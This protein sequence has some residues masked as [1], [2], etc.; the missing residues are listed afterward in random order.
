ML[1]VFRKDASNFKKVTLLGC[2]ICAVFLMWC[3]NSSVNT[4]TV[5]NIS[6]SI[7]KEYQTIPSSALDNAQIV[8][9]IIGARKSSDGNIIL[10]SSTLP[11]QVSL[12]EFAEKAKTRISQEMI[13]YTNSAI[14]A[15][16]F[17]CYGKK[18]T[19]YLH[20][21]DKVEIKDS[22]KVL[23]SYDQFYFIES[24]SLY[25]LSLAQSTKKSIVNSVIDSLACWVITTKK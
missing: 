22:S 25:I 19:W 6:F 15:K 16:K 14:T 10:A 1:Q 24:D 20:S 4:I 3:G 11:A 17:T 21:F 9:N 13:G 12:K 23:L 18:K 7:P 2:F 5:E 8:H